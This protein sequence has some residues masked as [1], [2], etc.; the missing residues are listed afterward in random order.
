MLDR[1]FRILNRCIEIMLDPMKN[2]RLF[3]ALRVVVSDRCL[4]CENLPFA[5]DSPDTRLGWWI[6]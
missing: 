6:V 5:I 3:N 4:G 1:F 2:D